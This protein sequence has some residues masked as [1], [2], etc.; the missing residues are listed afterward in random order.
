VLMVQVVR[1]A[2]RD[3]QGIPWCPDASHATRWPQGGTSVICFGTSGVG[4]NVV[5]LLAFSARD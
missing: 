2:G 4:T 3:S 5:P 1:S